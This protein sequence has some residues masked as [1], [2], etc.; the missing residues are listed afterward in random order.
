VLFADRRFPTASGRV[1]LIHDAPPEPAA[2]AAGFPALLLAASTP[3]A[4]SSQWSLDPRGIADQARVH[5][6]L[7]AGLADDARARLQSRHGAV[8]VT[9]RLDPTLH[10]RVILLPKGGGFRH[11]VCPNALLAAEETDAGGGAVYY[12][13]AV[14]LTPL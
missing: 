10:P 8:E 9:I 2:A 11:G 1:N 5:P 14:R 13:E 12:N 6:D 3:D 4:Q 7:A